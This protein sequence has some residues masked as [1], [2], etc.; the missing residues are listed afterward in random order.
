MQPHRLRL[1]VVEQRLEALVAA[2]ARLPPQIDVMSPWSK[3]LT[4][5]TPASMSRANRC[6]LFTSEV[7]IDAASP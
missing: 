3:Q 4:H 1:R 5:T 2:E 7:Q 6:A